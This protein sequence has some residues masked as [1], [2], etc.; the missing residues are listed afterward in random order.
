ME[1]NLVPD[2]RYISIVVVSTIELALD[3]FHTIARTKAPPSK[4]RNY[5]WATSPSN[6]KFHLVTRVWNNK[7]QV[8]LSLNSNLLILIDF[9]A[10]SN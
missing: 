5:V 10:Y 4:L 8:F 1:I 9:V 2:G 6:K 7:R 3:A